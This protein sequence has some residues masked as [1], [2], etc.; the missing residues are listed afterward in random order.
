MVG[1]VAVGQNFAG[2][3]FFISTVRKQLL[4]QRCDARGFTLR[5]I[6]IIAR[7]KVAPAFEPQKW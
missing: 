1:A 2:A 4:R 6:E 3:P 5:P 7:E